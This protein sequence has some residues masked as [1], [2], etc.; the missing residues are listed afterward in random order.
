[1]VSPIYIVAIL[2]GV[3]FLLPSLAKLEQSLPVQYSLQL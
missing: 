3:G 2:L 1:M